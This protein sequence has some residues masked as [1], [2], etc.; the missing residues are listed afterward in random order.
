MRQLWLKKWPSSG[1]LGLAL[2]TTMLLRHWSVRTATVPY[3]AS[4]SSNVPVGNHVCLDHAFLASVPTLGLQY[5]L[6][7]CLKPQD[8]QLSASFCLLTTL[9]LFMLFLKVSQR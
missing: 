7:L 3:Y 6:K 4:A 1:L 8:H 5:V 2:Y 9:L